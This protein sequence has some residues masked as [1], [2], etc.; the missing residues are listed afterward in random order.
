MAIGVNPS[1]SLTGAAGLVACSGSRPPH[2]KSAGYPCS[3]ARVLHR[4]ALGEIAYLVRFLRAQ[5][6]RPP[7]YK[8]RVTIDVDGRPRTYWH[9]PVDPDRPEPDGPRPLL[10][11]LHGLGSTGSRLAWWSGLGSVAPEYGFLGVFPDSV[12]GTWDD[13]GCG[14]TDGLDDEKFIVKLVETLVESG[15]ADP[16]RVFITGVSTG[17]TLGERLVRTGLV[18]VRG[19]A[20]VCGTARVASC[21]DTP[22]AQAPVPMMI[23]AGTRDPMVPY[24]GGDPGGIMGIRALERVAE[25]LTEPS[26]HESIAPERL[27]AEWAEA[28][29][30]RSLPSIEAIQMDPSDPP[31][32]RLIWTPDTPEGAPLIYYRIDGGGHG[33]PGGK[34]YL[35]PKLIGVIPQSLKAT[36][37]V[38]DFASEQLGLEPATAA[39]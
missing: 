35:P 37:I 26:G 5:P 36:Q 32:R 28:N 29:G 23:F 1:T 39:G 8:D 7:T 18:R 27:C 11:A 16:D 14:R 2:R 13:H 10:L 20:L 33:W 4:H 25:V 6:E 3:V 38:L 15:A 19:A 21:M 34:Q 24:T 31:V 30:C 12:H 9:P 17:A 22:I